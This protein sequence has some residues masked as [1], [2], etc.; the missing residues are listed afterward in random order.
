MQ[1][2]KRKR[3]GLRDENK[4]SMRGTEC[5]ERGEERKEKREGAAAEASTAAA[6]HI[7]AMRCED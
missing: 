7:L 2:E 3:S 4:D 6:S 5:Q 1:E